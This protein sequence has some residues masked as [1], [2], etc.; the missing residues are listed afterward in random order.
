M[1]KLTKAELIALLKER[2]D[3]I[4]TLR[5]DL[6][7]ARAFAPTPKPAVTPGAIAYRQQC[8]QARELAMRTGTCVKV[9]Q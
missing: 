7:I 2:N 5:L 4:E 9:T 1:L 3:T 6:S 8:A